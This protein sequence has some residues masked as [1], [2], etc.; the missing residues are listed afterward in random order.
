MLIIPAIDIIDGKCV[1]LRQGDYA[2]KTVYNE[3]PVEVGK[4]FA[5]QGA[6]ILHIVDLDGAKVGRPVNLALVSEIAQAIDIPVELGGGIRDLKT[7]QQVLASGVSRVILGTAALH[8]PQWLRCALEE[9]GSQIV[10]GIDARDGLVAVEGWL[11]TSGKPALELAEEMQDIGV[12]EII[13]TD[14]AKD[15]MLAGPNI[16]ALQEMTKSGL[17]IV[18]SGGVTTLGDI[19]ELLTLETYGVCGIIIG[20]AIYTGDL[21]LSDVVRLVREES[22]KC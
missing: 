13:Y 8:K 3:N 1:R 22:S 2:Q 19:R 15:G 9:Y 14:I 5:A 16:Q 20:K 21:K 7:V 10:V 18:A 17:K 6:D 11:E 4:Q 12:E